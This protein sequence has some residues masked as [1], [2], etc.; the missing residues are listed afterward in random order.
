MTVFI[1]PIFLENFPLKNTLCF[2]SFVCFKQIKS[3][4]SIKVGDK[5]FGQKKKYFGEKLLSI[6][7]FYFRDNTFSEYFNNPSIWFAKY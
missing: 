5:S 1:L 3:Y 7:P 6:S 4:K 2:F